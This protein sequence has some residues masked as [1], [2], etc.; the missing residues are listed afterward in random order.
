MGQAG[1]GD[2]WQEWET[3]SASYIK[4]LVRQVQE[5]KSN[6][7]SKVRKHH[8]KQIGS[9]TNHIAGKQ[10]EN[11]CKYLHLR[12]FDNIAVAIQIYLELG[13]NAGVI[14]VTIENA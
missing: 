10:G 8:F 3:H 7:F 2:I 5:Y 6:S 1:P 4:E 12:S 9:S 14:H 11:I 13:F